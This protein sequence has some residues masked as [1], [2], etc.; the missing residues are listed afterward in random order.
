MVQRM[1]GK[2]VIFPMNTLQGR[3]LLLPHQ[4]SDCN[5]F[6]PPL[7]LS[8]LFLLVHTRPAPN[9]LTDRCSA[10]PECAIILSPA[11]LLVHTR[12]AP[13]LLTD[14]CN[15]SRK[16]A[17]ILISGRHSC[18]CLCKIHGSAY[19][20]LQRFSR[21]CHYSQIGTTFTFLFCVNTFFFPAPWTFLLVG[22]KK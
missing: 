1:Q 21:T 13:N 5:Y 8:L 4:F 9:L 7:S 2:E 19:G 6:S 3:I 16:R 22:F 11:F 12:T 10:S 17:I 14:R 15:A 18:S 20:S